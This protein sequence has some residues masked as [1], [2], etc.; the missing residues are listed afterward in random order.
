FCPFSFPRCLSLSKDD[1]TPTLHQAR[2]KPEI[3]MELSLG[4]PSGNLGEREKGR[5]SL[6]SLHSSLLSSLQHNWLGRLD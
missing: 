6:S 5:S 1:C 4:N 3:L 2:R